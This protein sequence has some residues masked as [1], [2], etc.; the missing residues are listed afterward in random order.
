MQKRGTTILF[1]WDALVISCAIPQRKTWMYSQKSIT[2]LLKSYLWIFFLTLATLPKLKN[3]FT[4]SCGFYDKDYGKILK[5]HRICCLSMVICIERVIFLS[6]T[7]QCLSL[8]TDE[9]DELESATRSNR[10][11][12]TFIH[13][14]ANVVL[15][16][17]NSVLPRRM[18]LNFL[19]QRSDPLINI[20]YDALCNQYSN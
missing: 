20:L 1:S 11:I 13:P 7:S 3:L 18:N 17:L 19:L 2:L 5:L 12:P 15:M 8:R 10:Q 14:L 9:K 4:E 16:F 6:L